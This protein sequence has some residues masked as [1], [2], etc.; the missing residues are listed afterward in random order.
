MENTMKGKRKRNPRSTLFLSIM[1]VFC[2]L[3][4]VVFSVAKKISTEMSTSAIHNLSDS[5]DLIK[6]TLESMLVKETEIQM[7]ISQEIA[8]SND[9]YEFIRY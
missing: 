6:N 4:T 5:L 1:L 9:S 7:L 8:S 3:G 2:I